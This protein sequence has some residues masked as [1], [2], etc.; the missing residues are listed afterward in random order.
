MFKF[1]HCDGEINVIR[2]II[3]PLLP[4]NCPN[5]RHIPKLFFI[6][7]CRGEG[8]DMAIPRGGGDVFSRVSGMANYLVVR[9]TLPTI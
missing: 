6:D 1:I 9:S 3:W 8:T 4:E 2:K 5:L 7:S